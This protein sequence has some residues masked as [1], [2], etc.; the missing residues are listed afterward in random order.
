M[1]LIFHYEF[2]CINL[3]CGLT[4]EKGQIFQTFEE[5]GNIFRIEFDILASRVQ[6]DTSILHLTTGE[7]SVKIPALTVWGTQFVVDSPGIPLVRY[8][9]EIDRKYHFVI[10]QILEDGIVMF[11]VIVDGEVFHSQQNNNYNNYNNVIAYVSDPWK[12]PF[13]GC[14][15]NLTLTPGSKY[16]YAVIL[17]IQ[18]FV[19]DFPNKIF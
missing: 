8:G 9:F 18:L 19:F 12:D 5:W 1:L 11:K 4:S 13:D 16:Y 3:A 6:W 17:C 7:E 2:F 15:D 14:L 10:E